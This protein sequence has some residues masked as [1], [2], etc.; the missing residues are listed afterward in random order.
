MNY[1]KYTK[2]KFK[3]FGPKTPEARALADRL[4]HDV[5]A[6]LHTVLLPKV[7]KIVSK[8]NAGGHNLT[9]YYEFRVGAIDYCGEQ[10]EGDCYLRLTFDTLIYAGY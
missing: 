1:E 4:Q 7:Q 5:N 6:E 9:P 10:T 3:A 8:L 2:A